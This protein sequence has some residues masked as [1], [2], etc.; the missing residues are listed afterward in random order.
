[1]AFPSIVGAPDITDTGAGTSHIITVASSPT[2]LNLLL[3]IV[4]TGATAIVEDGTDDFT[5]N[6]FTVLYSDET[7]AMLGAHYVVAKISNGTESTITINSDVTAKFSAIFVEIQDWFGTIATGVEV[8][9]TAYTG[10]NANF[11]PPSLSP[12]WGSADTLWL[13]VASAHNANASVN[14]TALTDA[15]WTEV[16]TALAS[17]STD[18]S[19]VMYRK[20]TAASSEDPGAFVWETGREG[21]AATI[22]IRPVSGAS[23]V[24]GRHLLL[25]VG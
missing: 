17:L 23:V 1:M 5:S 10:A 12:A 8:G 16:S 25:G 15:S 3:G 14:A 22:G 13:A 6:G 4:G 24:A 20:N 11:D 19:V 18:A 9:S 7:L 2:S 21:V